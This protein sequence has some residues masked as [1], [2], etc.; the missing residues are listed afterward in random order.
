MEHETEVA[1]EHIHL[2]GSS[3]WPFMLALSLFIAMIGF[4]FFPHW[5]TTASTIQLILMLVFLIVGAVGM[6]LSIL[7][8]SL[9]ISE[10][11]PN[12]SSHS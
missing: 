1:E 7:F 9:Q 5:G 2:P 4:L 12:H 8:W 11:R 10:A 3:V 6:F